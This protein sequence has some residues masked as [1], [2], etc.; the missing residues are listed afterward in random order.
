MEMIKRAQYQAQ[1]VK[2]VVNFQKP[3]TQTVAAIAGDVLAG[4]TSRYI[5]KAVTTCGPLAVVMFAVAERLSIAE[6]AGYR[7]VT[8]IP[9]NSGEV[10][11]IFERIKQ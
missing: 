7:F 2:N 10:V 1:P 6:K 4:Q 11:M 9:A 8:T 5:L 3:A